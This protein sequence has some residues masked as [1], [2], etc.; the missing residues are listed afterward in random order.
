[1]IKRF[2]EHKQQGEEFQYLAAVMVNDA[3]NITVRCCGIWSKKVCVLVTLEWISESSLKFFFIYCGPV[4][5]TIRLFKMVSTKY[6]QWDSSF[7]QRNSS[8]NGTIRVSRR[9]SKIEEL[10]DL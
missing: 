2:A 5:S 10:K 9:A 8:K 3:L 7:S 4:F 6:Y 1:M